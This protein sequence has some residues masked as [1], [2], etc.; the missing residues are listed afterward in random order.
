MPIRDLENLAFVLGHHRAPFLLCLLMLQKWAGLSTRWPPP[1]SAEPT[2]T[3]EQEESRVSPP[4]A[5]C[6]RRGAGLC[7]C[8]EQSRTPRSAGRSERCSS[9]RRPPHPA[10]NSAASSVGALIRRHRCS[11]ICRTMAA[12]QI[13][14]SRYRTR[15]SKLLALIRTR[16]NKQ[17][18]SG[19]TKR[20]GSGQLFA[21]E[22]GNQCPPVRHSRTQPASLRVVR[23]AAKT[24]RP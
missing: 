5:F 8:Q 7:R 17:R 14:S 11:S 10:V 19:I 6:G 4:W 24:L 16:P 20:L 13:W 15:V 12:V 9:R 2:F 23:C 21:S 22:L 18:I 3:T 1:R